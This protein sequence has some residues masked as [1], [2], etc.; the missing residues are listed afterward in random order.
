MM[1]LKERL[2]NYEAS[3]PPGTW[4]K[5]AA[6]IEESMIGA[7]FQGTLHNMEVTPPKSA[8]KNIAASLEK[9]PA[10]VISTRR[11]YIP[12]L[13]YAA[14]AAVAALILLAGLRLFNQSTSGDQNL[15]DKTGEKL[16]V[17][18]IS[19]VTTQGT[20]DEPSIAVE[21]QEAQDDAALEESKHTIAR[22][23]ARAGRT[24]SQLRMEPVYTRMAAFS[25]LAPE[26]TYKELDYSEA[27]NAASH[28]EN[29]SV[30]ASR[31]VMMMTPDGQF[32]RMSKKLGDLV[33]CVSGEEQDPECVDQIN[34]WRKKVATSTLTPSPG[35][36]MDILNLVKSLQENRE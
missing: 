3:P 18:T 7:E 35:N 1:Q 16:P 6:A 19:P 33:C 29:L 11:K 22:L 15:V 32:I 17:K 30:T 27:L 13:R 4:N 14:A 5:I 36:F 12:V 28:E 25:D 8:W 10:V 24:Q 2:Y 20:K 31:Y 34:Q 26:Q 21:S 23:E 9:E